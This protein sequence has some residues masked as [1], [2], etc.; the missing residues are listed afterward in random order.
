MKLLSIAA[1]AIMAA[2]CPI[3]S[4]AMALDYPPAGFDLVTDTVAILNVSIA[5]HQFTSITGVAGS[6]L[7]VVQST[8]ADA[9]FCCSFEVGA[10]TTT[11]AG[12]KGCVQ[13]KKDA[14][15]GFYEYSFK[16]WAQNLTLRCQSFK[17]DVA[18]VVRVLQGR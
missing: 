16:R 6:H 7:I 3:K 1:L 4:S 17:T 2:L 10:V 13:A 5:T 14:G 18:A 9:G 12:T 11:V 15:G 8:A